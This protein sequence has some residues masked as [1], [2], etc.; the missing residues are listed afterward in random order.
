MSTY[1][2]HNRPSLPSCSPCVY[3][4]LLHHLSCLSTGQQLMLTAGPAPIV[5][6]PGYPGYGYTTPGYAAPTYGFNVQP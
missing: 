5:P 2:R 4:F 3:M 1:R 6:Q